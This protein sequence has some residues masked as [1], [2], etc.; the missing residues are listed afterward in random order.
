MRGDRVS[1]GLDFAQE[2]WA[3]VSLCA[4][5]SIVESRRMPRFTSLQTEGIYRVPGVVFYISVKVGAVTTEPNRVF[6]EESARC[7]IKIPRPVE[8]EICLV[9]NSRPVYWK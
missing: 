2:Y 3:W 4:A 8:I 1:K 9:S 5:Y 7:G 6:A